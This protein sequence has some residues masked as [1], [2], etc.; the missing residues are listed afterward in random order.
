MAKMSYKRELTLNQNDL[1]KILR[2]HFDVPDSMKID[3]QAHF[4]GELLEDLR[5]DVSICQE[6][7]I[8]DDKTVDQQISAFLSSMQGKPPILTRG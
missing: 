6:T 3:A 8:P 1:H 5:I 4:E 2:K 7:E